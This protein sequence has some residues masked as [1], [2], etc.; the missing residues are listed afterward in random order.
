MEIKLEKVVS[1]ILEALKDTTKGFHSKT[2]GLK[3][4]EPDESVCPVELS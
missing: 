2:I 3:A 4:Y 1:F